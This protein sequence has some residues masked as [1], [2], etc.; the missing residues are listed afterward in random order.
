MNSGDYIVKICGYVFN[1]GYVDKSD[2][3]MTQIVQHINTIA[4]RISRYSMSTDQG[5]SSPIK[6]LFDILFTLF[7]IENFTNRAFVTQKIN[8]EL[9][10]IAICASILFF[11]FQELSQMPYLEGSQ[12]R[13]RIN[14]LLQLQQQLLYHPEG[15]LQKKQIDSELLQLE[16][17]LLY[18]KGSPQ[19]QEI[20]TMLEILARVIKYGYDPTFKLISLQI[21]TIMTAYASC[22]VQLLH[23]YHIG[24]VFYSREPGPTL[25]AIGGRNTLRSLEDK[26]MN[27]LRVYAPPPLAQ[28]LVPRQA[29]EPFQAEGLPEELL[30]RIITTGVVFLNSIRTRGILAGFLQLKQQVKYQDLQ[31]KSQ[32]VFLTSVQ[33]CETFLKGFVSMLR[34]PSTLLTDLDPLLVIFSRPEFAETMHFQPVVVI[35]SENLTDEAKANPATAEGLKVSAERQFCIYAILSIFGVKFKSEWSKVSLFTRILFY[36]LLSMNMHAECSSLLGINFTLIDPA[37]LKYSSLSYLKDKTLHDRLLYC[38]IIPETLP[39]L[40]TYY[41]NDKLYHG[42]ETYRNRLLDT[43]EVTY[44]FI[45]PSE[46]TLDVDVDVLS[47]K[48]LSSQNLQ[49]LLMCSDPSTGKSVFYDL[50][51]QDALQPRAYEFLLQRLTDKFSILT[52]ECDDNATKELKELLALRHSGRP[53]KEH[54][55][56]FKVRGFDEFIDSFVNRLLLTGQVTPANFYIIIMSELISSPGNAYAACFKG[57]EVDISK[58][59]ELAPD[60]CKYWIY[61]LLEMIMFYHNLSIVRVDLRDDLRDDVCVE[62]IK[63]YS[64]L[65]FLLKNYLPMGPEVVQA[66]II[67]AS[68]QTA[69]IQEA[70]RQAAAIEEAARQA[71]LQQA[72]IQEAER[73]EDERQAVMQQAAMQQV[74]MQQAARQAAALPPSASAL[75]PSAS[76]SHPKRSRDEDLSEGR[77]VKKTTKGT[78]ISKQGGGSPKASVTKP[79]TKIKPKTRNN[80]RYSKNARTRRHKH[81]RKQHRNRKNKKTKNKKSKSKKNITFKRRRR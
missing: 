8:K 80:N 27:M 13:Q 7:S 48:F 26:C 4:D 41:G 11:H 37:K 3:V 74:G 1:S 45:S 22:F 17:Q 52:K 59:R 46:R 75:P 78:S 68:Q 38:G 28:D 50:L 55:R 30:K 6:V 10:R 60:Q 69:G 20:T 32:G 47:F 23:L 21:H 2:L 35:K 56:E 12:E 66:A 81:K 57:E 61:H 44:S 42:I 70:A 54:K 62:N 31:Y 53:K 36:E 58:F 72:A 5:F 65:L 76:A 77:Y 49:Q 16:Q 19:R 9:K 33:A 25:P 15:S 67:Q 79:K 51:Q 29:Q 34:P 24:V 71:A 63:K 18:P 39:S 64:K 14:E 43:G 40:G 73:Q